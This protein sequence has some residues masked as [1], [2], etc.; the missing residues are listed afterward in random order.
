MLVELKEA[1]RMDPNQDFTILRDRFCH[2]LELKEQALLDVEQ[3]F[4]I[5][6]SAIRKYF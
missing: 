4:L 3:Q 2:L 5:T 1:I 6:R